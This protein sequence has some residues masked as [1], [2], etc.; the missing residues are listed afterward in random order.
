MSSAV[1][2][3]PRKA[4]SP[5]RCR[6]L[7]H[8]ESQVRSVARD[9]R[10]AEVEAPHQLAADGVD[11]FALLNRILRHDPAGLHENI[12]RP[13]ISEAI[14]GFPEQTRQEAEA[15]LIAAADEPAGVCVL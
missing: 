11:V 13:V 5:G 3:P 14:F 4:K 8:F 1:A 7:P 2:D 12:I 10:A 6:G 9:H 15:V